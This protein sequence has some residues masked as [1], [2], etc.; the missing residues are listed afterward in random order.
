MNIGTKTKRNS[1]RVEGDG[2]PRLPSLPNIIDAKKRVNEGEN[3]R[4][5]ERENECE[6]ER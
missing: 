3:E 6:N 2:C 1:T 4:E 5:N